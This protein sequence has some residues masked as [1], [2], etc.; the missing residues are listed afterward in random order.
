LNFGPVLSVRKAS[1]GP[2]WNKG[3]ELDVFL[4]KVWEID[5]ESVKVDREDTYKEWLINYFQNQNSADLTSLSVK[6]FSIE[7]MSRRN[8]TPQSKS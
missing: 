7:R 3:Q 4:S 1:D 8:H 5:D 2:K 6:R